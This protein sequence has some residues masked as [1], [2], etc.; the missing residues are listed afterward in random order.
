MTLFNTARPFTVI[1]DGDGICETY[2][3]TLK[4]ALKSASGF[5]PDYKSIKIW[6]QGEVV[7]VVRER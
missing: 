3:K 2:C 7:Q 6:F 1:A 5:H 4:G